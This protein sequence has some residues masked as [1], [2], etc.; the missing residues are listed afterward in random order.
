MLNR[1]SHIYSGAVSGK[2]I[3]P[4]GIDEILHCCVSTT[5]CPARDFLPAFDD[6][7]Y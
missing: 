4:C 6:A 7:V 1:L 5:P 3:R 2:K